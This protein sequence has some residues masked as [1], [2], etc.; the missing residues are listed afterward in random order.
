MADRP[1]SAFTAIAGASIPDTALVPIIDVSSGTAGSKVA[2]FTEFVI[3]LVA[4]L[5]PT[6]AKLA[7]A[8]FTGAYTSAKFALTDGATI[9]INFA[10]SNVQSVTLGG[11]RT[12]TFAGAVAGGR[13]LLLI[14]QDGTGSRL[15]TWPTVK[16]AGGT[17]PTLTTTAGK[18]DLITIIYDGTSYYGAASLNF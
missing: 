11:S 6:F 5:A 9:A 17:T 10:N 15:I 14:T 18:T 13:Y 7:G 2:V 3:K 4:S 12:I 1:A 16:W 8:A